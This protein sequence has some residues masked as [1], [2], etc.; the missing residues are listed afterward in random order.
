MLF[1]K[2]GEQEYLPFLREDSIKLKDPFSNTIL[3]SED[4]NLQFFVR[5]IGAIMDDLGRVWFA[6]D[7]TRLRALLE[8]KV[9]ELEQVRERVI[10]ELTPV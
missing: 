5:E 4:T 3:L 1:V 7:Y 9:F 6:C 10:Q 8:C 2:L